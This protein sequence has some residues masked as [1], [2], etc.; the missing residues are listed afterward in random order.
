M[1]TIEFTIDNHLAVAVIN[2]DYSGLDVN[3]EIAIEKWCKKHNIYNI[4]VAPSYD[5]A[6]R[7]DEDPYRFARCDITGLYGDCIDIIATKLGD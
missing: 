4:T 6:L 3:D 2:D 5:Q 1:K 7:N